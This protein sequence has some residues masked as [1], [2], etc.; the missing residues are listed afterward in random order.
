MATNLG[1][2]KHDLFAILTNCF[3]QLYP[4]QTISTVPS[5]HEKSNE[6]EDEQ[7]CG[8]KTCKGSQY[9]WIAERNIYVN[10]CTC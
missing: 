10:I 6:P 2:P 7:S 4:N 5:R 1:K 3:L 8:E 9:L